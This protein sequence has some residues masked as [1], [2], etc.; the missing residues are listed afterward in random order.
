[1]CSAKSLGSV[2]QIFRYFKVTGK[3]EIKSIPPSLYRQITPPLESLLFARL[4][5]R[6]MK[7]A[8]FLKNA[9]SPSL[10]MCTMI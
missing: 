4:R 5:L 3:E 9:A 10:A 6:M 2:Q 7:I 1:M 8:L